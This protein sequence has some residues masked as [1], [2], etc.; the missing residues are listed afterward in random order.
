MEEI[1]G[2]KFTFGPGAIEYPVSVGF[3]ISLL[4]AVLI[5]LIFA[6]RRFDEATM[7]PDP[8]DPTTQLLPRFLANRRQ[9]VNGRLL[10]VGGLITVLV[11]F[12][13][14]GPRALAIGQ[15][16]VPD[17]PYTLPLVVALVIVG[18]LPNFPVVQQ[19]E[20][21]LRRFAHER[22]FIPQS[23]RAIAERIAAATFDF[24]QYAQPE[25]LANPSMRGV[26][27]EDF[28]ARRGSLERNWAKL[29]SLLYKLRRAHTSGEK[30]NLDDELLTRYWAD[31][32]QIATTRRAM[33]EDIAEY[34]ALKSSGTFPNQEELEDRVV[35]SLR[36]VYVLIGCAAQLRCL[37]AEHFTNTLEKFGFRFADKD[38]VQTGGQAMV[39]TGAGVVALT[40]FFVA[41]LWEALRLVLEDSI[42]A[43]FGMSLASPIRLAVSAFI[44]HGAAM[45]VVDRFR[46]GRM[47]HGGWFKTDGK[48][49]PAGSAYAVAA[50]CAW[51]ASAAVLLV[52]GAIF[53]EPSWNMAGEAARFALLPTVS[54]VF[55]AFQLDRVETGS[56]G[57][58]TIGILS[59]AAITGFCGYVAIG[60]R[61]GSGSAQ[62]AATEYVMQI[63]LIGVAI[64]ALLGWYL[65]YAATKQ[66]DDSAE[67]IRADVLRHMAFR[68][69]RDVAAAERWLATPQASLDG[70][71]PA[72]A[73]HNPASFEVALGLLETAREAEVTPLRAVAA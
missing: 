48:K 22:A 4:L 45:L 68:H 6:A 65:S 49:E 54:G 60:A 3:L 53:V 10:Y 64:G 12:S 17:A 38:I 62:S 8:R 30:L 15:D 37:Q 56:C 73:M 2:Y 66:L 34:R 31:V 67:D 28:L 20:L 5:I 39:L 23:A 44:A 43:A 57:N 16:E 50:I 35:A 58:T 19:V 32:E 33:E 71:S 29:S 70:R 36:K 21:A 61:F 63:V 51:V 42:S 9:Y 1:I 52:W 40:V 25:V 46:R 55:L 7:T 24:S 59:Q 11:C 69:F 14:L 41:W 13:A 18:V 26:L 47:R 27:E 72:G